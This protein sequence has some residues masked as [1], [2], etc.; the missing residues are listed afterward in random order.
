MFVLVWM[1]LMYKTVI[2][3]GRDLPTGVYSRI[4]S[5]NLRSPK[6]KTL[7][8]GPRVCSLVTF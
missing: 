3:D 8:R 1:P 2:V 4:G 7:L 5:T 6:A